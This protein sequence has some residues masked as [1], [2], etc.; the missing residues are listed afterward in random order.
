MPKNYFNIADKPILGQHLKELTSL[1]K[2][3]AAY[4][5]ICE[6]IEKRR[7]E[8]FTFRLQ[9]SS[10]GETINIITAYPIYDGVLY[11]GSM[12]IISDITEQE[13]LREKL[14]F[15][16]RLGSVGLL[17][18][19]V[20]HEINNPLEIIMNEVDYLR[21][22]L[23]EGIH[24]SVLNNIEDEIESIDQIVSS[25]ASF[26]DNSS[27][28]IEKINLTLLLE[29]ILRLVKHNAVQRNIAL[30]FNAPA[31][32]VILNCNKTE[33]KQIILNLVK[34]SFEA[35]HKDGKLEISLSKNNIDNES[36][37]TMIVR[38]TGPG[39]SDDDQKNIFLPFF[40]KKTSTGSNM[41]LGLS[42]SYG[43]INKMNGKISVEN[44][45]EGGCMF[46]ILL[47]E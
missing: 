45:P 22:V 16:E 6:S 33:I 37:I 12:I 41:G 5:R 17:A 27:T 32:H 1:T 15:S 42:V 43:I 28:K 31:D 26:S 10:V 18:A 9:H 46:T 40:S 34:N 3:D 25:L 47:P 35:I 21:R 13:N 11:I 23:P 7:L 29:H 39:I 19:G 8:S 20:S 38:D 14:N 30:N 2:N 24:D 36:W 4:I 44:H